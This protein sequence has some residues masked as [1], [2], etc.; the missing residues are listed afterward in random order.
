[1]VVVDKY[2]ARF[3]ALLLVLGAIGIFLVGVFPDTRQV[4][5]NDLRSGQIH[6]VVALVAFVGLGIGPLWYGLILCR[7][8]WPWIPKLPW[9][10]RSGQKL[11]DHKKLRWPF[12]FLFFVIGCAAYFLIAWEIVWPRDYKPLGIG[13]WPGEGIYSFPLWEWTLIATLFVVIAWFMLALPHQ[14]PKS[15]EKTESK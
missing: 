8:N 9:T 2:G 10:G 1:M 13:H 11:F 14:I 3:A 5:F 6:N 12:L 7:D 4:F 15:A